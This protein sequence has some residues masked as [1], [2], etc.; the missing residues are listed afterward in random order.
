[1][2][3]RRQMK[4]L[5]L[6]DYQ[7][8]VVT[9]KFDFVNKD[10]IDEKLDELSSDFEVIGL[11]GSG[12]NIDDESFYAV[13]YRINQSVTEEDRS[14]I[15]TIVESVPGIEKVELSPLYDAVYEEIGD[16]GSVIPSPYLT[17]REKRWYDQ[18]VKSK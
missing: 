15:A 6:G 8:K 11:S 18:Y 9:L 10:N 2:L 7:R 13:I 17:K 14:K 3:N 16:D 12:C 5:L 4:K 1:M